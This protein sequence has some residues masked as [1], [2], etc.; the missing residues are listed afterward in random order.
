MSELSGVYSYGADAKGRV[1]V[2]RPF[3]IAIGSP[4]VLTRG[5]DATVLLTSLRAWKRLRRHAPD[6]A[7]QWA[8]ET[9]IDPT[10]GR[11]L[12]PW[13]LRQ[14]LGY[15]R[16]EET[17]WTAAEGC[18]VGSPRH[19]CG[20]FPAVPAWLVERG[21]MV[22]V[23]RGTALLALDLLRHVPCRPDEVE[24]VLAVLAAVC[25]EA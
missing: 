24:S 8:Q 1:V 2:P 9:A 16:G 12:L 20:E 25:E 13:P 7:R 10:T 11:V 5:D 17:V 19:L 6:P 4:C 3:R 21:S 15:R 23:P 18:V 22:A 14:A